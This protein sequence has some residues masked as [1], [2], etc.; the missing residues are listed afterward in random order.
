[1]TSLK[2]RKTTSFLLVLGVFAVAPVLVHSQESTEGARKV[3]RKVPPKYPPIA[4]K[5]KITGIVR[6]EAVVAP[7]G[8]VKGVSIK[9]GH[10]LLAQAAQDTIRDW[11][12]EASA[13]ESHELIEVKFENPN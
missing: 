11:K 3:L 2:W 13:H 10:P 8:V 4:R 12:W 1:M 6:I 9:G 7:N 5:M